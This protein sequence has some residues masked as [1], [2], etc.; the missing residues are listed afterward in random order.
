MTEM[1]KTSERRLIDVHPKLSQLIHE[2]AATLLLR[3]IEIRVTQAYRTWAEQHALWLQGR[4]FLVD[5]NKCRTNCGWAVLADD[6]QNHRVTK[7]DAGRSWHNYGLAVDVAPFRNGFP[8]YDEKDAA[9]P[10]VVAAGKA[11]GLRNGL[12]WRDEPHFE[13]TGKFGPEPPDDIIMLYK[14][15]NENGSG[16]AAVW[17]ACEIK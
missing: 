16:S 9:W 8:I 12:S 1:D 11:I 7:A 4:A 2:L 14:A 6:H 10:R 15:A 3:G 5:V 13:L 17:N